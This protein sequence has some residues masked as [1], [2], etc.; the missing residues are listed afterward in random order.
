MVS[1]PDVARV[2]AV[3]VEDADPAHRE[4]FASSRRAAAAV[5]T[6][7]EL[8]HQKALS[9]EDFAAVAEE[10]EV[11][12]RRLSSLSPASRYDSSP[13]VVVG[14][15][16]FLERYEF[17]LGGRSTVARTGHSFKIDGSQLTGQVTFT[18]ANEGSTPGITSGPWIAYVLDLAVAAVSA[19]SGGLVT[20]ELNIRYR[21]PMPILVQL[22]V[23]ARVDS[24]D[25]RR[26]SVSCEILHDGNTLV[27]AQAVM[28]SPA[29]PVET[30][31]STQD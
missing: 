25:G 10:V 15:D 12:S 21:R 19:T 31:R 9:N 17:G 4:R 26:I 6:L 2:I 5:R 27:E 24:I 29:L 3:G 30:E 1:R 28:S 7:I 23:D 8:L 20:R 18:V 16:R 11:I 14:D 22:D 13:P